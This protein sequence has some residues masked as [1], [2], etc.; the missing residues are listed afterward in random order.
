MA[1]TT[2]AAS[3]AAAAKAAKR[4]VKAAAA[5]EKRQRHTFSGMC[6]PRV[7]RRF[8]LGRFRFQSIIS[9]SLQQNNFVL[10]AFSPV[11]IMRQSPLLPRCVIQR[12]WKRRAHCVIKRRLYGDAQSLFP[13]IILPFA[14]QHSF[15]S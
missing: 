13:I 6:A 4:A 9:L 12:R 15:V 8:S 3:E 5:E 7:S 10:I 1:T 2:T 14:I 11:R